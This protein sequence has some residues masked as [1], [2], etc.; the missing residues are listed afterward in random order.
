MASQANQDD[1]PNKP[2]GAIKDDGSVRAPEDQQAVKNQGE[3]SPDDYP[4]P[5]AGEKVT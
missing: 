4:H 3:V 2:E 5:A 1:Q